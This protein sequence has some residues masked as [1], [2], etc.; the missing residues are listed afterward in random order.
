[1]NDT[2]HVRPGPGPTY[3]WL[4]VGLLWFCGFFNYADRQAVFSVFPLIGEEFHLTNE[5]LGAIGS[6]FMI[7]YA[8]SAPLAG[9]V[10]DR[11]SRRLLIP[12][13]LG[14]W[15]LIC[16]ATGTARSF[17]A[18]LAYRAAEGLGESFY[19][20]ASMS[21]IAGFHGPATRS[22]AM[23]VH[24][25]S[26]YA[27]TAAG[28]IL[29]GYIGQ[30]HGW[31]APFL[32][33]G[34]IG[35]AYAT[36]LPFLL[37]E[38]D[39][40]KP[41]VRRDEIDEIATFP[42]GPGFRDNLAAVLGVPAALMLLAVFA[43]AN[44]VAATLLAWLPGFVKLHHGLDLAQ[45]A[46]VAGL[47]F[48][49][50]NAVGALCGGALADAIAR[51]LRGGRVLVQAAGLILGAP[52]VWVAGTSTSLG[53]LQA[54]LVGIGLCKGVYDAN[55]FASVYDVVRAEVRGTA[56]GLMNTVAWTA[57]SA[58]PYLVGRLSQ[59]YGLGAVIGWTAAVY[60]A[61]GLLALGAA[62]VVASTRLEPA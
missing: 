25:T 19:F 38:P 39:A 22:R 54:A 21:L 62:G 40:D 55:I 2:K 36:A 6:S 12:L 32:T 17:G 28:G 33:L 18:L 20:P 46:T 43:G 37:R 16:A 14:L 7:V 15:S 47:Y 10:V 49:A 48:P 52:C 29:A 61:A 5:Q 11:L 59:T 26:V 41:K 8:L 13:G 58:A 53:M 31:R 23:S 27:G 51:R 50:G 35:L 60:L 56:A 1:M 42:T 57:G 24:Q 3:P 9:Y 4:V 34:L 30:R 44:F 45:A